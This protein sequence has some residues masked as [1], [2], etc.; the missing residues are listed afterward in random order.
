MFLNLRRL[1]TMYYEYL[2]M[3]KFNQQIKICD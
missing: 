3:E 1:N 2:E